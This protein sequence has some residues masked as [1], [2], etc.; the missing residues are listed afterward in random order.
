MFRV[1]SL[2][3]HMLLLYENPLMNRRVERFVDL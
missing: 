3:L 1:I 2:K